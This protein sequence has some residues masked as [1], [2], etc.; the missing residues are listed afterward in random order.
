MASIP[1]SELNLLSP[2]SSSDYVPVVK[3]S[4]TTTFRSTFATVANWISESV[5]A[6]SSYS[7]VSSSYALSSSWSNRSGL[8]IIADNLTY[9]N[10]S[11]ASLAI[12]AVT[13][14]NANTATLAI[15]ASNAVSASWAPF[16][17]TTAVPSAS[18]ASQSLFAVSASWAPP[19]ISASW[20]SSSLSS[21][22]LRGT[23]T[24]SNVSAGAVSFYGTASN[25]QTASYAINVP[26]SSS[27]IKAFASFIV[28]A[29]FKDT[30]PD[31]TVTILKSSNI[32]SIVINYGQISTWMTSNNYYFT[33]TFTN[34]MSDRNYF[35]VGAA[36]ER[37]G[38]IDSYVLMA[39]PYYTGDQSSTISPTT[40]TTASFSF[41]LDSA[42][43]PDRTSGENTFC[44][45]VVYNT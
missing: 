34:V 35:T 20:A 3:N 24:G 45:F 26:A 14:S 13:A 42:G 43:G 6:S 29:N 32:A 12:N 25:A 7:S 23:A 37:G 11:T 38:G 4:S 39:P 44:H 1:I 17:A 31:N 33:V 2:I 21:S 18:W 9:P 15:S 16:T 8:A 5:V 30:P 28:K 19:Q 10:T 36:G 22:F 40:H 27:P 41:Y